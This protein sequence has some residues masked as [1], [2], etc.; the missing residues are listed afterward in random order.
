[1]NQ[2]QEEVIKAPT[3]GQKN[4][5]DPEYSAPKLQNLVSTATLNQML[6]L[7]DIAFKC[8]NAEYNPKRFAA[9]IMRMKEPHRTTA[10]IFKTGKMV[11]TGA[12]SEE[13]SKNAAKQYEKAI[14]KV[15]F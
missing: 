4:K 10:L 2:P 6:V 11:I 5:K 1:M 12:K 13:D 3:R 9:V 14:K 15:G 8:R 7:K